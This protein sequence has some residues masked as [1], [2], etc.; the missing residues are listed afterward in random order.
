[1]NEKKSN[2]ALAE[3]FKTERISLVRYARRLIDDA[4]DRDGEDIVQDVMLNI[5]NLSDVTIPVENLAAYVYRSLRNKVTDILKKRSTGTVSMDEFNEGGN[6]LSD[7]L[8]DKRYDIASA[9]EKK[10][11]V[12]ELYGAVDSLDEEEKSIIFLTEFE[13]RSFREISEESGIPVGTLLSRKSRAMKKIRNKLIHIS[14]KEN[15]N[16]NM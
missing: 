8:H 15:L 6:S 2:P 13:S 4:A 5:F 14:Y 10:E 9:A 1:M 12:E 3:F 16:E 7:I 11:I